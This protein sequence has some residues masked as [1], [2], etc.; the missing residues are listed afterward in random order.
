M[1]LEV[2]KSRTK[3]IDQYYISIKKNDA[4]QESYNDFFLFSFIDLHANVPLF[5]SFIF[6][7][8]FFHQQIILKKQH[9]PLQTEAN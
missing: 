1:K 3:K 4:H 8:N 7:N 6:Y 5:C 9:L 2:R